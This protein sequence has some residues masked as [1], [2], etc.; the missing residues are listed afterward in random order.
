[1]VTILND[2]LV[3][4]ESSHVNLERPYDLAQL[5]TSCKAH[6]SERWCVSVTC[7]GICR[8]NGASQSHCSTAAT[9]PRHWHR[10]DNHFLQWR[11]GA[12]SHASSERTY[13]VPNTVEL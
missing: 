8:V 6:D 7:D 3:Y 11:I 10:P 9:F 2:N 5:D 12:Q 1:M 13:A 4:D